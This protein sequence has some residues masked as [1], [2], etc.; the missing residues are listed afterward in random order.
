MANYCITILALLHHVLDE[1]EWVTG[2]CEHE[3]LVGPPTD[4]NGKEL[5]Y[6][7]KNEPAF[8]GL[9]KL[10]MDTTWLKSLKFLTKFR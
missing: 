8:K 2:A 3:Q 4:Q 10:I 7:V 6:F 5:R 9:Q 1:H